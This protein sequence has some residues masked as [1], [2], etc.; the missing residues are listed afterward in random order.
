LAYSSHYLRG[1]HL[2]ASIINSHM[3]IHIITGR[4]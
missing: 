4:K 1:N 2:I 3:A